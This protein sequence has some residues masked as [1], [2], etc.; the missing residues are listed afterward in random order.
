MRL[1]RSKRVA[2]CLGFLSIVL[3]VVPVVYIF[4]A[5][6]FP[7]LAQTE[8]VVIIG[9]VGGSFLAAVSAG[10]IGSRWWLLATLAAAMDI[11]CLCGFSP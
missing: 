1:V 3:S 9:G 2:S 6:R 7:N 11:V 8:A 10:V 5:D 4:H